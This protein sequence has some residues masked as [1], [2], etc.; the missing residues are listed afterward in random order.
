MSEAVT[1]KQHTNLYRRVTASV[2][3]LVTVIVHVVLIGIAG[4]YVVSEQIIGKK[5]TFE[6][7]AASESVAQKQ[8]E[9]RLQVAR[10]SGGSASS[11][12]VSA[13]RIF[14]TASDA[15]QMAPLPELPSVGASSLGGMGFGAGVGAAGIGSGFS[16]GGTGLA[17]TGGRGFMSM[18]FIGVTSQGP[19]KIVFIVDVGRD[20]L[21]I[22]KGGFEAFRIIRDEIQKL[23]S[24]LP[25]NA[26]FGVVLY[27]RDKWNTNSVAAFDAKLLPATVANKQ[28]FFEWI[29]PVNATPE[30]IGIASAKGRQVRW[31]PRDVSNA[32]L[33]PLLST[34]EWSR[35]LHFA[36]EMEPGTIYIISGSQGGL[37]RDVS[38]AELARRKREYEER[39]AEMRRD[40]LDPEEVNAARNRFY[41]KARAELNA[42]NVKLRAQGKSPLIITDTRRIFYADFQAELKRLGYAIKLDTTGWADKQGRP[43]WSIGFTD[44]TTAPFDE[45]ITHV[46]KLQRVLM[47]DRAAI[48][49]F[50]F[51][52][53]D[54]KP[55]ASM[56]NLGK[57]TSRNGG[58]FELLTT[59]RLQELTSRDEQKK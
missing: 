40:G 47:K 32:G 14:S 6:A 24:R 33:D 34:P 31:T 46:S 22:R 12:P 25:P 26:E 13:S 55:Q 10:K 38:A 51:V 16:T 56:D 29:A 11:S 19:S 28:A 30:S 52:G 45:L 7:S 27:E 54:E 50:L 2:P 49:Y 58:R 36:L 21:D 9:H 43:I 4:Y 23:I 42:I 39:L 35:A 37:R 18:S 44:E 15:M 53:P 8:V 41:A 57:F 59:R 5:K 1:T 17:N 3:L 20:L 48:H